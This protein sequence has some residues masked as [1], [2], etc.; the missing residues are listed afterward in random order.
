MNVRG[1]KLQVIQGLVRG[2]VGAGQPGLLCRQGLAL[3]P[4]FR[5]LREFH[6]VKLLTVV[7]FALSGAL[8]AH[9]NTI[10]AASCQVSD[11]QNAINSASNGDTV[12]VPGGSCTW[13]SNLT[14]TKTIT[15]QGAGVGSTNIT[16]NASGTQDHLIQFN[17]PASGLIRI[18]GFS[19]LG[20]GYNHRFIECNGSA[21][22]N[23]PFRIDH[24]RFVGGADGS[25]SGAAGLIDNFSCAG[26]IDHNDFNT[27]DNAEDIHNNGDGNAGWTENV[28]IG[29]ANMLFVENNTFEDSHTGGNFYG[30]SA[31]QSYNGSRLTFRNNTLTGSQVDEHGTAGYV[32]ARWWEIYDN[33]WVVA[34]NTVQDKY[35][36]LRGGSGLVYNNHKTGQSSNAAIVVREEDTGAWPLA[37]QIGSGINGGTDDH[38]S[39]GG[40]TLNS[41]P[42]HFWGNDSNM[43]VNSATSNVVLSRDFLVTSG[44]PSAIPAQQVS[45]DTCSST[46]NYVP[47]TYPHPL[48]NGSSAPAPP[49]GLSAEVQ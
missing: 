36:D 30:N 25:G 11:V 44:Q 3:K 21:Y 23:A 19:W 14:I 32:G 20:G 9:A 18:T 2:E 7:L 1:G 5:F 28:I 47:Y 17:G 43:P 35:M 27:A 48:Q 38:N 22:S 40:G 42:A 8:T 41:S 13:T 45:T 10:N 33:T 4:I 15:L 31:I 26:L 34:N 37:Y 29:G 12:V 24:N 49:T 6:F 16:H 46:Y 39:C